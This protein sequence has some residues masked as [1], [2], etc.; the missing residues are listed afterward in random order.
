MRAPALG[1]LHL[2]G[3][4]ADD[5][6]LL[7]VAELPVGGVEDQVAVAGQ[8]ELL[9]ALGAVVVATDAVAVDSSA[10]DS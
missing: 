5:A 4:G 6:D 3:T 7:L 8:V 2:V 1:H 9:A 10:P